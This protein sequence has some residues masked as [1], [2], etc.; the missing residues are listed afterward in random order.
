MKENE[1]DGLIPVTE[2]ELEMS[3]GL[4]CSCPPGTHGPDDYYPACCLHDCKEAG[5]KGSKFWT[6]WN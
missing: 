6:G 2:E 3:Y 4:G 1:K 5:G